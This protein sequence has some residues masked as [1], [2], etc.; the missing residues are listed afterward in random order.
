MRLRLVKLLFEPLKCTCP[1]R[2]NA[3]RWA[4]RLRCAAHPGFAGVECR[5]KY[6]T[7]G[8][9]HFSC[10]AFDTASA[11][12]SRAA[13]SASAECSS[14]CWRSCSSSGRSLPRFLLPHLPSSCASTPSTS[15]DRSESCL[16]HLGL[17]PRAGGNPW[18]GFE[19]SNR[20]LAGLSALGC[21]SLHGSRTELN[22][23]RFTPPKEEWA[24]L[25][26][27]PRPPRPALLPL[28][29]LPLRR[30]KRARIGGRSGF[31]Q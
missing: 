8:D 22:R 4:S 29:P 5:E 16:S 28:P 14:R 9:A 31:P 6:T 30:A 25:P 26:T 2:C 12:A 27:L 24:L 21:C 10:S 7:A 11:V 3:S 17:R 23:P 19:I 1:T 15:L 13:A 18:Q 20:V